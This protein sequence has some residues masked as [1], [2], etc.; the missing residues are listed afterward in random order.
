MV[1]RIQGFLWGGARHGRIPGRLDRPGV[2]FGMLEERLP[3]V[4]YETFL[5]LDP[6]LDAAKFVKRQ[7][8]PLNGQGRLDRQGMV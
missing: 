4:L 3:D 6:L 8:L 2:R 1:L 5:P 7:P